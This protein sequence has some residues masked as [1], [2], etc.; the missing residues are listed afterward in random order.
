MINEISTDDYINKQLQSFNLTDSALSELAK[1]YMPLAIN[2]IEDKAGYKAVKAA[3]LD[4]KNYR[5]SVEKRRKELTSDALRYKQAIDG[6][7]RRITS[8]LTP[9]EAHLE[10]QEKTIDQEIERIKREKEQAEAIKLQNRIKLLLSFDFKFD[11]QAYFAGYTDYRID[12]P[13][14]KSMPDD[15]FEDSLLRVEIAFIKHKAEKERA[16]R[17]RQAAYEKQQD[18]LKAEAERLDKI[19][20]EQEAERTRLDE[21]N[22]KT[23]E[24]EAE[25]NEPERYIFSPHEVKTTPSIISAPA[26]EFIQHNSVI[27]SKECPANNCKN[28]IHNDERNLCD[29]CSLFLLEM[30]KEEF[31]E[32]YAHCFKLLTYESLRGKK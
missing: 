6:E 10:K 18:E 16:E 26:D 29:S 27:A 28:K 11:G 17:E 1:K 5:V 8:L 14:L 19:R 30:I 31:P 32:Q 23:K 22:K 24:P 3:R 2:G 12:I 13:T 25:G 4:I 15:V 20:K 7:A 21:L 9:I